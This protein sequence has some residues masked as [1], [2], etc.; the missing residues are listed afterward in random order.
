MRNPTLKNW[1]RDN[2][3]PIFLVGLLT[4][5]I[6]PEVLEKIFFVPVSFPIL[7]LILIIS[8][9]AIIKTT[10]NRSYIAYAIVFVLVVYVFIWNGNKES[11][12]LARGAY[13]SLFAYFS[14][15]VYFL[16]KDLWNSKKI[17]S[18]V[19][20]GAFAGYFMVGVMAFFVLALMDITYP[21]TVSVDLSHR[22]G[23][24]DMFYFSFVTLT[25][26]G[27]GDFL[28]TSILGHKIVILEAL[29]GQFY[30]TIVMAILIGK[31]LSN[32]AAQ[33]VSS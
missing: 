30:L 31:Y 17:T 24:E 28:P 7:I 14:I 18:S 9:I 23:I 26:I 5:F 2:R 4:F 3:H 6:L 10:T 22:S 21:D 8:S 19:I 27:Y 20:I 16:F 25:T 12:N 15:I 29:A 13:L 11:Y 33:D 32:N 1:L